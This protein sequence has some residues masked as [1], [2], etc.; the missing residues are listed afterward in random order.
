VTDRH[1]SSRCLL[2]MSQKRWRRRWA[3]EAKTPPF[4]AVTSNIPFVAIAQGRNR[5]VW[6]EIGW[7]KP[8]IGLALFFAF[9]FLHPW[10]FGARPYRVLEVC[11]SIL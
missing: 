4:A 6:C 9:F 7:A 8:L 1:G 5:I 11:N 10:L 3:R 2:V